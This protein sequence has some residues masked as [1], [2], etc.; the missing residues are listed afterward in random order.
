MMENL[1]L[2]PTITLYH[3]SNY[4]F[5]QKDAKL[6]KDQTVAGKMK[7]MKE[8]YEKEGMRTSVEGIILMHEHNHPHILLLKITENF[9]KL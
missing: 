2:G 4:T 9:F 3:I 5:G 1:P 8:Q 6:E 7:R